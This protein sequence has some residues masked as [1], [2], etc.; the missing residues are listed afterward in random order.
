[1]KSLGPCLSLLA[2]VL[3]F[4]AGAG[5]EFLPTTT[6]EETIEQFGKLP[7]DDIWWTVN[8]ESM[9]WNNLNLAKFVPAVTVHRGGPVREL[10][11][12]KMPEI[13]AFEV[14]TPTGKQPFREF[15][16]SPQSTTMSVLLV[17]RG[18]IVFEHYPRQQ[19]HDK[20]LF[21][22]V[23]KAFVSTVLAILEDR[24]EVDV[25]KPVDHYIP[26]LKDSPYGG[27][28][29]RDVLDMASG[30]DCGDEYE[31][32]SSCYYRY[33]A[34]IGEGFRGPEAADNPYDYIASLPADTRWSE[35]GTGYSYSGVDTFVLGWLVEEITGMP[36]QDALSREV[37]MHIGAESDALIWAGRYGIPLTSG[38]LMTR[39]RDMA[40]FGLLF[41]P[42]ADAVADRKII[43]ARYLDIILHGARP[44]LRKNSAYGDISA[45][46]VLGNVYQW[47]SVWENGDFMKGGWAGQGLMI[48]P[49]RDLVAV[50]TGYYDEEGKNISVLPMIR[51]IWD[52][53]FG[54]SGQ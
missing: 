35:P 21:W 40:R 44:A 11:S 19:P 9:R 47:D 13:A 16:E 37:W 52:G 34:S 51:A 49:G 17:H 23:T 18:K 30:I 28:K 2:L 53:V 8:G 5:E 15:L 46:G 48:N 3:A 1:M 22:S 7:A 50:W 6:V 27:V 14:E 45:E 20:P 41:T 36:F 38:G 42:S 25:S 10:Q 26:R 39:V 54:D 43:S 33:S 4:D 29:I 24:G 12:R 31:D 32:K